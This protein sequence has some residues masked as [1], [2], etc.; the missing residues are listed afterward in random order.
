MD[1]QPST[2]SESHKIHP[3]IDSTPTSSPASPDVRSNS[4]G[5]WS[6]KRLL[7]GRGS[8]RYRVLEREPNR[9]RKR[10]NQ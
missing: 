10:V 9:L 1:A 6:L 8:R 2:L 4:A 5:T 7:S 3:S